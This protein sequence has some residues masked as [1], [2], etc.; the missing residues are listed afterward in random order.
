M[1]EDLTSETFKKLR[2]MQDR[3]DIDRAWTINGKI[4]YIH[5]NETTVKVLKSVFD[6]E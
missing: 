3:V 1:T 5:T 6:D 4:R 2:E